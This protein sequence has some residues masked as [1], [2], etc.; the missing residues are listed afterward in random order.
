[1][2]DGQVLAEHLQGAGDVYDRVD[3]RA[4]AEIG[5]SGH[6]GRWPAHPSPG[7]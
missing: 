5:S 6:P 4:Q 3:I 2:V 7:A 1:L